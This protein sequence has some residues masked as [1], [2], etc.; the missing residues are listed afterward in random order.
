MGA[1][2]SIPVINVRTI[3]Y[4]KRELMHRDLKLR[5][6]KNEKNDLLNFFFFLS[7]WRRNFI[8]STSYRCTVSV[9]IFL[10][11][12]CLQVFDAHPPTICF[13]PSLYPDRR[14]SDTQFFFSLKLFITFAFFLLQSWLIVFFL[15]V[16]SEHKAESVGYHFNPSDR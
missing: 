1:G 14:N 3:L 7:C 4:T 5:Q 16:P 15:L 13:S 6:E 8:L 10:I 11:C 2:D 12:R 9:F